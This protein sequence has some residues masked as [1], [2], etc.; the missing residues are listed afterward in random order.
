MKNK[1]AQQAMVKEYDSKFADCS[2]CESYDYPRCNIKP[3]SYY[4]DQVDGKKYSVPDSS[5]QS[6]S[7]ESEDIPF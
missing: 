5:H 7:D 1:A 4:T 2:K 3:C 6:S